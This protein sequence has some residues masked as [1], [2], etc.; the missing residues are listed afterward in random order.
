MSISGTQSQ[1]VDKVENR[2]G[3]REHVSTALIREHAEIGLF[4]VGGLGASQTARAETGPTRR[5]GV[6]SLAVVLI[7]DQVHVTI[8]VCHIVWFEAVFT[9]EHY[10][11]VL[12]LEKKT[13][14]H[15]KFQ[16]PRHL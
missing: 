2:K 6:F 15:F 7:C 11:V 3:Y 10:F 9:L 12:G 14:I 5:R 16:F 13:K 4:V 1:P 8:C